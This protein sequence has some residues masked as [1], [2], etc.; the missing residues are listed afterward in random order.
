MKLLQPGKIGPLEIKNRV[1]L[2][3]MGMG[4]MVEPGGNWGDAVGAYYLARARGGVGLITTMLIF[5]T[6]EL[7]PFSRHGMDPYSDRH[8]ESL[9][10]IIRGCHEYDCK[11][12]VQLTAGF[13]RV[14][15]LP[16]L[17]IEVAPVSASAVPC[18]FDPSRITRAISTAETEALVQAFGTAARRCREAGA[19]AVELHGHEGY[20]LDQFMTGLWNQ[21]ED[22]Y[23]G[24]PQ[25]RLTLAREAVA[26]IKSQAGEDFPVIYRYGLTH[27]LEHGRDV[28]EGLWITRELE[29]MGVDAL[30][31]DAGCYETHW[32]PH[33]PGYQPPGCM[34]DMAALAKTVA[35]IPVIAVGRLQYPQSAEAALAAEQADFIAIGRGLLAE[36]EWVNKLAAGKAADITPCIGCHDGC[37]QTMIQGKPT[38]CTLNP[39]CGHEHE[40]PLTKIAE[41]RSVLVVGSGPAGLTAARLAAERGFNVSLWE[42]TDRLGGNLWPAS[43]PDFK[44]DLRDALDHMTSQLKKFPVDVKLNQAATAYNVRSFAADYVILATGAVMEPPNAHIDGGQRLCAMDVLRGQSVPGARVVVMG[45][46]LI[47]CETALYLARNGLQVTLTS[48][49]EALLGDVADRNNRVMLRNLL[50]ESGVTVMLETIPDVVRPGGVLATRQ[51]AE[52]ELAADCLVFSG[53]LRPCDELWQALHD[54]P[55][56]VRVGDCYQPRRIINAVWEAFHAI[57]EIDIVSGTKDSIP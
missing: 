32:W 23:G 57:R 25:R 43:F 21:R 2:A 18:Y 19:D 56:V 37:L 44:H 5:V 38:S 40:W 4:A 53:R 47:G 11:V 6:R 7:E 15:N 50:G 42:Q 49:R 27:Y 46:G 29:A 14:M 36:P 33:P 41:P 20:L 10:K 8:I 28:E 13:G 45:G 9:R 39:L 55:G 52:L 24:S 30:H 17:G 1:V 35:T 26:A 3:P 16:N 12:S 54:H 48:R 31:V 34:L 51:G 22:K